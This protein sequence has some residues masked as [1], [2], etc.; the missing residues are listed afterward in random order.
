MYKSPFRK[1]ATLTCA[2]KTKGKWRAGFHTGEDWVCDDDTILSPCNARVSYIGYDGSGYGNY[3]ILHTND[4]KS[5]LMAHFSYILV[6]EGDKLSQGE[7]IGKMGSTGNSTGKHLHIEV[8]NYKEWNYGKNLIKPSDYIDF[9]NF[10]TS[11]VNVYKN[12]STIEYVYST[13]SEC[14]HQNINDSIG[15][16][17]PYETCELLRTVDGVYLVLYNTNKN[18]KKCGFVKFKGV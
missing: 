10:N 1:K 11:S 8:E 12:G 2:F 4:G 7:H 18:G 17:D 14:K 6:E 13:V 3:I 9:N 5:I 16:L 15:Y